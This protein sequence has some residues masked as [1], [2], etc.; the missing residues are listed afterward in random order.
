MGEYELRRSI[1]MSNYN[2]MLEHN[3]RYA[4]GEVTWWAKVH[5]DM[6]LTE[7]EWSAKRLGGL[8]A[9]DPNTKASQSKVHPSVT[10]KLSQLGD[11]P[12]E[13][14]W[15]TKGMVSS[16]KDQG[17]CGSCAAFSAIGAIESC[18]LIQSDEMNV[19]LSEQHIVD[20]A[21]GHTYND[22]SGS[23][24]ASGCNGAWP[25]TYIDWLSRR[26]NQDE[27]GY[28]YTYGESDSDQPCV[29]RCPGYKTLELLWRWCPG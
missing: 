5:P 16:V 27:A 20:C 12:E 25:I 9:L 21:Y 15:V 19:D 14:N 4:A 2:Q 28:K 13:F 8:P 10:A 7:E 22:E 24:G 26:N 18:Y 23:W 17:Q 29:H 1:F 11:N 3:K 6:D